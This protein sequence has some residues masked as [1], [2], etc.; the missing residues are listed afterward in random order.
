M[1]AWAEDPQGTLT[2]LTQLKRL[3]VTLFIDDFGTVYASFS[4]L[5]RLPVDAIKI[6]RSFIM[7]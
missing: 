3:G 4:Y 5:Q 1:H 7:P 6:D 2:T